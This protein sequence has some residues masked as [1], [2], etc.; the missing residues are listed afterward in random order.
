MD[1]DINSFV[2][3]FPAYLR[4][5]D[6]DRL[7]KALGQFKSEEKGFD[8]SYEHFFVESNPGY[9]MQ[10]DLLHEVKLVDW[11]AEHEEYESGYIPA[12]LLSNTCDITPENARSVNSKQ[13]VF[14]PMVP[15][16]EYMADLDER[17][18]FNK[19]QLQEFKRTVK[20]QEFSNLFYVPANEIDHK[21]YLV[22]FDRLVFHPTAFLLKKTENLEKTRLVSLSNTGFYLLLL[23]L[24]FHFCRL[25]EDMDGRQGADAVVVAA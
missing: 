19:D 7:R 18:I 24:S 9:L 1:F 16:E 12:M 2:H 6:K 20:N 5:P 21:E 11:D 15:F 22:F 23:K 10:G 8:K 14:A 3:L 25:P 4:E 17:G 13:S